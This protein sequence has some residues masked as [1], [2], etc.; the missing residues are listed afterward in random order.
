MF[1]YLILVVFYGRELGPDENF[2][3]YLYSQNSDNFL[4]LL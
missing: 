4:R 1:S 2:D 3:F